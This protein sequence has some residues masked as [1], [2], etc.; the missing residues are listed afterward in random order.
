[1]TR[2]SPELENGQFPPDNPINRTF[3]SNNICLFFD[4]EPA[5]YVLPP[6][7]AL[8]CVVVSFYCVALIY[9]YRIAWAERKLSIM[10][11]KVLSM[12]SLGYL[13][14]VL[15][16]SLCFAVQPGDHFT[17]WIH[18]LP[19]T[20]LILW[21]I[22]SQGGLVYFGFKSGWTELD[23]HGKPF[24]P[25]AYKWISLAHWILEAVHGSLHIMYQVRF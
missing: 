2:F 13:A 8:I 15:G 23:A 18:T 25:V 6:F 5:T 16:F 11:R 22:I 17:M 4:F 7:W 20:N 10:E 3:G 24:L 19:F 1:M 9:R 14:A 21:Q 12:I